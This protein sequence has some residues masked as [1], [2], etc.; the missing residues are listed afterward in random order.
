MN[1]K[2][3]LFTALVCGIAAVVPA[4]GEER[5][6]DLDGAVAWL[7]SS[8]STAKALRGRVVLINFWTYSCINS[9][10]ELP[11]IKGWADKYKNSGLIVIGVHTP[12]FAFEKRRANVE[13][14]VNQLK[15][16]FPVAV[17][18]D[19]AIWQSFRNEYW[20]A[21][22]L[23]DGKGR[24]RYRHFGEGDYAES[25]RTIQKLLS[26]NGAVGVS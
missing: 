2:H 8:P 7:N 24:I 25:E 16:G 15:I 3:A 11:Y 26:E 18:S 20:P 17:D 21:D 12:E 22:Y 14:A 13:A 19:R 10:R 1:A 9:L 6:P 23:I 5:A 4:I